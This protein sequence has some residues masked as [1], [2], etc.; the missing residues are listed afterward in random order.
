MLLM[1]RFSSL[2]IFIFILGIAAG[3]KWPWH[4]SNSD[5]PPLAPEEPAV[6]SDVS[7]GSEHA[8][9]IKTDGSL[10]AWGGNNRGQLGNGTSEDA[11]APTRVKTVDT[12]NVEEWRLVTAGEMHGLGIK[13]TEEAWAWGESFDGQLTQ[14]TNIDNRIYKPMKVTDK[15][16]WFSVSAGSIHTIVLKQDRTLWF[17]G[18]RRFVTTNDYERTRVLTQIDPYPNWAAIDAGG[19]HDIGLRIGGTLWA[20]GENKYGQL[21]INSTDFQLNPVQIGSDSDW[22]E[23]FNAGAYHCAAIKK[24]GS[25]W[26]W[27]LN[28]AGQLGNDSTQDSHVPIPIAIGSTWKCV[29]TGYVHTLAVRSDG[30]LWAWGSNVE[31]QLGSSL[32]GISKVPV[33]VGT[34]S[35]WV[36]VSAG[37]G[38]SLAIKSDGSLWSW[39]M[40]NKGQLGIGSKLAMSFEPL[41]VGAE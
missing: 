19:Y 31:G 5:S 30:T 34:D 32:L 16:E 11:F 7:A 3:C 29:S 33:Q 6:W 40:N 24:D 25:L 10:W 39:G 13:T 36:K 14:P 17:C 4:K 8:L 2:I 23:N 41:P 20:W 35:D 9:A 1:K 28:S 21:G 38:F 26:T 22:S 18:M 15:G 27:G 37:W 12:H